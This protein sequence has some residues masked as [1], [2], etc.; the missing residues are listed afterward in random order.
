MSIQ[1]DQVEF[2]CKQ[3][4]ALL[5]LLDYTMK[6][7]KCG[8]H[9]KNLPEDETLFIDNAIRTMQHYKK[10]HGFYRP[11]GLFIGNFAMQMFSNL[12]TF[13]DYLEQKKPT[14]KTEFLNEYINDLTIEKKEEEYLRQHYRDAFLGVL[15]VYNNQ[16]FKKYIEINKLNEPSKK[17]KEMMERIQNDD[18]EIKRKFNEFKKKLIKENRKQDLLNIRSK[19]TASPATTDLIIAIY[20]L[21]EENPLKFDQEYLDQ[22]RVEIIDQ[23]NS[24]GV[25]IGSDCTIHNFDYYETYEIELSDFQDCIKRYAKFVYQQIVEMSEP[26]KKHP[27]TKELF[28]QAE[29]EAEK[30][31]D[32][33]KPFIYKLLPFIPYH[34][35]GICH[36]HWIETKRILKE[37]HG[38]D[39]KT[40][41]ERIPHKKF[42]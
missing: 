38:I 3:C 9:I 8:R 22:L 2:Y 6:C 15:N 33:Q 12:Y 24:L 35:L 25:Y 26:I 23:N 17:D 32:K 20:N 18:G 29:K 37:K 19:K 5:V 14:N 34:P 39:W 27:D 13:F 21:L 1:I 10:D 16:G 41:Q 11:N 40:P 4:N 30:I 7:P 31:I 42:D 36:R 28:E